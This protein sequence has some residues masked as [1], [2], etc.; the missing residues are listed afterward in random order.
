MRVADSGHFGLA[1]EDGTGISTVQVE[2]ALVQ[3][4]VPEMLE[5]ERGLL[6]AS[7]PKDGNHLAENG[8]SPRGALSVPTDGVQSAADRRVKEV[9]V[10]PTVEHEGGE[11]FLSVHHGVTAFADARANVDAN[12]L[13]FAD[14]QVAMR[15]FRNDQNG[16]AQT[17]AGRNN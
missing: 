17:Q 5:F 2:S 11:R 8:E 9:G 7:V 16:I 14:E 6:L 10:G 3:G 4:C 12:T 15:C 1:A 13:E